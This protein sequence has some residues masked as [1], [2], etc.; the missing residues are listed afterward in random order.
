[1]NRLLPLLGHLNQALEDFR[2]NQG[3]VGFQLNE[4]FPGQELKEGEARQVS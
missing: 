2:L 1:M 3:P 4:R